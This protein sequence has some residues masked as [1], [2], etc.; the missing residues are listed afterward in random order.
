MWGADLELRFCAGP[1]MRTLKDVNV[2]VAVS[3]RG[4]W[5]VVVRYGELVQD[6]A[7][8]SGWWQEV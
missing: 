8:G 5:S 1:V 2:R 3:S 4:R 6:V 7:T